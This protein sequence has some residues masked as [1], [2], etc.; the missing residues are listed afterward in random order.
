MAATPVTPFVIEYIR[1]MV[2]GLYSPHAPQKT[3]FPLRASKAE[4]PL[5][6]P[7]WMWSSITTWILLR[8]SSENPDCSGAA[9]GSPAPKTNETVRASASRSFFMT[10]FYH[11]IAPTLSCRRTPVWPNE[12]GRVT[13]LTR[14]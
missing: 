9:I 5:S 6:R 10:G 1:T 14:F 11:A 3:I 13:L 7:D 4:A 12:R 8:R 2:S